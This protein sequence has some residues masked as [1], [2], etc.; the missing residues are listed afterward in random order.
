MIFL[1]AGGA[2]SAIAWVLVALSGAQ[3]AWSRFALLFALLVAAWLAVYLQSP[4]R[5]TKAGIWSVVGWAIVFRLIGAWAAPIYED[6]FY[7]YL[8][9]GH[10][11]ATTGTPYGQ[12]PA[13]WFGDDT[14]PPV[15]Q[16]VLD[17]VSYPDIPTIYGPPCE[18]LFLAGYWISPGALWPVKLLLL[19]ADLG[20]LAILVLLLGD[21]KNL[22]LYAWCPLVI[23][24]IAVTAHTD[25]LPVFFL[26]AAIALLG[27]NRPLGA[28]A[29]LALAIAA[30]PFAIAVAPVV[31]WRSGWKVRIATLVFWVLIYVPFVLRGATELEGMRAF[32]GGWEFNSFAFALLES[33]FGENARLISPGLFALIAGTYLIGCLRNRTVPRADLILLVLYL[34]ASVV[35]PW[36]LLLLA[37]FVALNPSAT[38]VA[39]LCAVLVSYATGRNLGIPGL[40]PFDHPE[41]VRPVEAMIVATGAVVDVV[42]K[43]RGAAKATA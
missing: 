14:V 31:V 23:K 6:D 22:L 32:A 25:A 13:R 5:L 9:D 43:R 41:W 29:A 34:F 8:W 10:A 12:P 40:G 15:M 4:A 27:R 39:A 1:Q 11:F 35:N 19:A 38:G 36:Y 3:P 26:L 2:L 37:P 21:S 18:F 28:A 33:A 16:K 7:R 30:R 42:L 20:A 17:H 24:E